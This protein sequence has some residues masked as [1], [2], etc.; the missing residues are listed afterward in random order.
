MFFYVYSIMFSSSFRSFKILVIIWRTYFYFSSH[1]YR[2]F[3]VREMVSIRFN[4]ASII[5]WKDISSSFSI[6]YI[7]QTCLARGR[8]LNCSSIIQPC[9]KDFT[10]AV[11]DVRL[12]FVK[13]TGWN[14]SRLIIKF[15][16][17]FCRCL[18][19]VFVTFVTKFRRMTTEASLVT[20]V[21]TTV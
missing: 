1:A 18:F 10:I 8:L 9:N 19:L 2:D 20:I 5:V 13:L 21:S 17:C 14:S 15:M 11:I 7:I 4:M 6:L 12:C 3:L 16:I